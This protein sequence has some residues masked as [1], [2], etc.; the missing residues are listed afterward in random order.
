MPYRAMR[1]GRTAILE[2]PIVDEQPLETFIRTFG[3]RL[4]QNFAE[5]VRYLNRF[6]GL[7][8]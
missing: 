6:K 5:A 7:A 3:T 1:I 2:L 4:E 8:A